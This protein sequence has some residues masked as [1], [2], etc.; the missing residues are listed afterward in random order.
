MRMRSAVYAVARCLYVRLSV[1]LST[2]CPSV[3]HT[4]VFCRHCWTDPHFFSS[5]GSPSIPNGTA[6]LRL[7]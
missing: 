5:P 3:W 2:V 7:G 6:V 1:R 4:P